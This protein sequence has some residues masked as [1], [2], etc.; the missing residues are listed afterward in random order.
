MAMKTTLT[1]FRYEI[2]YRRFE[3][4]RRLRLQV[5]D[6]YPEDGDN[7]FLLTPSPFIVMTGHIRQKS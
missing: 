1:F 6:I 7:R 5:K 3:E 4:T 2:V